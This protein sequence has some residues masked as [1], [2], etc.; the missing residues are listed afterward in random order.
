WLIRLPSGVTLGDQFALPSLRAVLLLALREHLGGAPD[1][2]AVETVIDPAADGTP[3][4]GLLLHDIVPGGTGYLAELADPETVWGM[5]HTA[6][7]VRRGCPCPT[8][9]TLGWDRAT[10]PCAR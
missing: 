8:G 3:A 1:H 7:Q 4:E 5:L 10:V 2:L 6:W 9:R